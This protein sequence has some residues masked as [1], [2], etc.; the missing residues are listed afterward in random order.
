MYGNS[1]GSFIFKG[2]MHKIAPIESCQSLYDNLTF[3]KAS[4][5]IRVAS[6]TPLY[7]IKI[8]PQF[9]NSIL[10]RNVI[11]HR[12]SML[13]YQNRFNTKRAAIYCQNKSTQK[14]KM[15][16]TKKEMIGFLNEL[17]DNDLNVGN[18]ASMQRIQNQ[19]MIK[20]E[21]NERVLMEFINPKFKSF[22][23]GWSDYGTAN[24]M[25]QKLDTLQLMGWLSNTYIRWIG[26]KHNQSESLIDCMNVNYLDLTDEHLFNAKR[27]LVQYDYVLTADSN[28]FGNSVQGKT[29]KIWKY[30]TKEIEVNMFGVM[31]RTS[32]PLLKYWPRRNHFNKT[33]KEIS[34]SSLRRQFT[35]SGELQLLIDRNQLDFELYEFAK[36]ISDADIMFVEAINV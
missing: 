3:N 21:N 2:I 31:N 5:P 33:S 18:D 16:T 30:F 27:I 15:C 29:E 4:I 17:F 6:E 7:F 32:L 35:E 14:W 26:Y 19:Q 23:I 12:L 20:L 25:Y 28:T 34:T 24:K 36:R 1:I 8:C 22:G 11:D 13:A 10:L 9:Y